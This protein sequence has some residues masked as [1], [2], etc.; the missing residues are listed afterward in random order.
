[1]NAPEDISTMDYES[2][3]E[4]VVKSAVDGTKKVA[5]YNQN[6]EADLEVDERR[7]LKTQ[8]IDKKP[9]RSLAWIE[10]VE[11]D[12]EYYENV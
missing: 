8:I 9:S 11:R 6:P 2:M 4:F 1:M 3:F 5:I 10:V 7:E 12:K